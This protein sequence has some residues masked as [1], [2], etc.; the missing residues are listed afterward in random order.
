VLLL[1]VPAFAQVVVDPGPRGGTPDAGEPFASVLANNPFKI[2]DF[3]INAEERFKEIGSVKGT[4]VGAEDDGLG[5]R[6]NALGCARCDSRTMRALPSS[7]VCSPSGTSP[8]A[9]R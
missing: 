2:L 5:P 7:T 6:F 4:I 8:R 1:T 9:A 3:F